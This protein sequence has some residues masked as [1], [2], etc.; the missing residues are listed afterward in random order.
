MPGVVLRTTML[1]GFPG[2][3]DA[4]YEELKEFIEE[5][6]FERLGVFPFSNEE[7]TYAH[8]HF[9]DD[10]PD[11]EKQERADEIMEI[12]QY[13]SAELNREKI[14]KT[15]KVIIDKKEGEF[16]VGRT[17]FDSPEV[18]G[19]VLITSANELKSGDF[20]NVEITGSED[21][22]LYGEVV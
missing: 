2:E 12:Q 15:L 9:K 1:V 21:Y 11:E 8:K 4:D 3:T 10:V 19:E 13:I 18:D 22:D 20:V 6:K 17:E 5:M 14:G 16:Y 7:G